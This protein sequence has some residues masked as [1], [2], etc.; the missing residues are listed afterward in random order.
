MK[1]SDSQE[2]QE[3]PELKPCPWCGNHPCGPYMA[4][5]TSSL[6][7]V[8]CLRCWIKGPAAATPEGAIAFWNARETSVSI[9]STYTS[10]DA[11]PWASASHGTITIHEEGD[12]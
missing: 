5:D 11:D 2:H 9:S 10:Q 3:Q 4:R 8:E 1:A 12:E 7:V 6:Y